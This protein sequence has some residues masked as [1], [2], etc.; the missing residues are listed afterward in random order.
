MVL[1]CKRI[2]K[3]GQTFSFSYLSS[4]FNRHSH[5]EISAMTWMSYTEKGNQT[6]LKFY[7]FFKSFRNVTLLGRQTFSF[8]FFFF[9]FFS[10]LL[11]KFNFWKGYWALGMPPSKI[12][13]SLR[14]P[15][16][17]SLNLFGKPWD[18]ATRISSLLY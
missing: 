7:L 1:R 5:T 6:I 12:E 14:F 17:L 16:I 8:F 4:K 2:H 11:P 15:K 13:I 10:L 9:F 18:E 3:P